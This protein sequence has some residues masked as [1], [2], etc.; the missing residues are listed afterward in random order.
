MHN[1]DK[2]ILVNKW[3]REMKK[4]F[5]KPLLLKAISK[6]D[7]YPYKLSKI[8]E[9]ETQGQIKIATTN[10]Y[11]LLRDLSDD[12]LIVKFDD[13]ES[14]RTYYKITEDGKKF[15]ILLKQSIE[16][17]FKI[18]NHTVLKEEKI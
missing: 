5:S 15:L 17:F 10:I 14:F 9:E 16:D 11:P 4:G 1:V 2:D 8:I 12:G 7:S 6:G 3:Q 13:A 18:I